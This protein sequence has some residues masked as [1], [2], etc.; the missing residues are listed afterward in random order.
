MGN[1][2]SLIVAI[3]LRRYM[4]NIGLFMASLVLAS[5]SVFVMDPIDTADRMETAVSLVLAAISSK[6]V[7][8]QE[9]PKIS[10]QVWDQHDCFCGTI[11]LLNLA[12]LQ[13]TADAFI[14]ACFCFLM[15]VIIANVIVGAVARDSFGT[16]SLWAGAEEYDSLA[17]AS[18]ELADRVDRACCIALITSW[19]GF[20]A[21][22]GW[23]LRKNKASYRVW[24][25]QALPDSMD[26]PEPYML[27]MNGHSTTVDTAINACIGQVRENTTPRALHNTTL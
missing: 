17:K 3:V 20:I 14:T 11:N 6:F 25:R 7:I 9:V 27:S 18:L 23:T 13:T 10:Y 12:F 19:V 15:F 1:K 16:T 4:A 5:W 8:A 2:A 22:L 26:P 21:Q 24:K